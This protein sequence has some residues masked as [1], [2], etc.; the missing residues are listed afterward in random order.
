MAFCKDWLRYCRK[1]VSVTDEDAV[2]QAISREKWPAI[3]GSEDFIDRIKERCG[4]KK[5]N[6]EIPSSRELLPDPSRII[7]MVCSGYGVGMT[8]ILRT[9]RGQE[10][11][12]RKVA[13]Y[14]I[15]NLRRATASEVAAAI[16]KSQ[17]QT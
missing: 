6:Q 11:E 17:E 5:T 2:S 10:N 1:W 8:D 7:D 16:H 4:T 12:P 13:I 9:R 14:L 3:L 15:W